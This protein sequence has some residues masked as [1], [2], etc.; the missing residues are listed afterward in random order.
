MGEL[1][2]FRGS[3]PKRKQ[4]KTEPGGRER[5]KCFVSSLHG[6]ILSRAPASTSILRTTA[7]LSGA[8]NSKDLAGRPPEVFACKPF[9]RSGAFGTFHMFLQKVLLRVLTGEGF[10]HL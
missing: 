1:C 5:K 4:D 2:R 7:Q 3:P 8:S 6:S 9:R 10:V